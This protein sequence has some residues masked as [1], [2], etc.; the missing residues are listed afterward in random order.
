MHSGDSFR[1]LL[2]GGNALNRQGLNQLLTLIA[3]V[4]DFLPDSPT[5]HRVAGALDQQ[6]F[7]FVGIGHL[8]IQSV[9]NQFP[10]QDDRHSVVQRLH[11]VVGCCR[12][13]RTRLDWTAG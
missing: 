13:N 2:Y 7:Q 8:G 11:E 5:L 3:N 4:P 1:T 6:R 12:A 9:V 10:R